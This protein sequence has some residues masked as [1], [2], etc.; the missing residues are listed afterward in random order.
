MPAGGGW[1]RRGTQAR[2][3]L[4]RHLQ[5][6]FAARLVRDD[7]G[8][9]AVGFP[10]ELPRDELELAPLPLEA[11]PSRA[12]AERVERM[13]QAKRVAKSVLGRTDSRIA[14]LVHAQVN[15]EVTPY[16]EQGTKTLRVMLD[17]IPL[18][19]AAADAHHQY[20]QRAH[21][22]NIM[23]AS[24]DAKAHTDLT[25]TLKLPRVDGFDVVPRVCAAPGAYNPRHRLYPKVDHGPRTI[26]VQVVGLRIP[27][28]GTVDA[29]I[30]PLRVIVRGAATGATI[31]V[32]YSLQGP[33][34][35]RPLRGRLKILVTT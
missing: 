5:G 11:L 24:R 26:A 32:A 15:G 31:R 7:L 30:E 27:R 4:R 6:I 1:I 34:L 12:A 23:L 10:G 17:N 18:E 29:F 14:R 2:R 33:T 20:E 19:Q 28:R 3:L 8:E 22:L 25:L 13:L 21:R 16:R 9:I 35:S